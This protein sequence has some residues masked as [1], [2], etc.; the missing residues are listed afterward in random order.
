MLKTRAVIKIEYCLANFI[1]GVTALSGPDA[2]YRLASSC[3]RDWAATGEFLCRY[4]KRAEPAITFAS[5][6]H[7]RGG[8]LHDRALLRESD[9]RD[10]AI[11]EW[12]GE[13]LRTRLVDRF[14]V[15]DGPRSSRHFFC[16]EVTGP[17]AVFSAQIP[18]QLTGTV[19]ASATANAVGNA[20][21]SLD[22]TFPSGP[23]LHAC[24]AASGCVSPSSQ[25]GTVD[26][27]AWL[28]DPFSVDVG[29]DGET[30][31]PTSTPSSWSFSA[32][33]MVSFAPGF[34]STGF[35]LEFS[36]NVGGISVPEPSSLASIV[37]ALLGLG[38]LASRRRRYRAD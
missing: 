32:A 30:L 35:T 12:S 37:G 8:W 14:A 29:G 15:S 17:G 3:D 28:N 9:S 11:R 5:R 4:P 20:F 27:S 24:V 34:D 2:A 10:V 22:S 21:I 18:L 36:P 33:P 1:I 13:C 16:G 19:S 31:N 6:Q 26:F 38:F 7:H 25:S 23:L